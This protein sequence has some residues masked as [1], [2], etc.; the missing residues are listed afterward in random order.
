MHFL[1]MMLMMMTLLLFSWSLE[2]AGEQTKTNHSWLKGTKWVKILQ[3]G[4]GSTS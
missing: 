1:V 2:A 3:F 4:P